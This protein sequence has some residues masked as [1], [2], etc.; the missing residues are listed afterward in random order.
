M[1]LVRPCRWRAHLSGL[2]AILPGH[3][4]II[5]GVAQSQRRRPRRRVEVEAGRS[6]GDTA[7]GIDDRAGASVR[8]IGDG[9]VQIAPL[10][11]HAGDE[12][13]GGRGEAARRGQFSRIGSA[14][15]KAAVA[16]IFLLVG[17]N[18]PLSRVQ[19]LSR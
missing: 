15:D 11:S 9:R 2:D 10:R 8:A 6:I 4:P 3:P 16:G 1:N 14:D 17:F 5:N 18:P 7:T 19:D 13:A 12:E